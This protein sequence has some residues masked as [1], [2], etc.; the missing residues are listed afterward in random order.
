MSMDVAKHRDELGKAIDVWCRSNV[1]D[2]DGMLEKVSTCLES[3]LD[4]TCTD[5]EVRELN[6]ELSA[7]ID[8]GLAEQ[9]ERERSW[10]ERTKND[11]LDDAFAALRAR[12]FAALQAAG[13][14]GKFAS[15]R[16]MEEAAAIEGCRGWVVYPE[17]DEVGWS[18]CSTEA[19]KGLTLI[20]GT[21]AATESVDGVAREVLS[22]LAHYDLRAK[23]G[24]SDEL[25]LDAFEW[26]KRRLTTAPP[27]RAQP[28]PTPPRPRAP[29]P[30]AT[31]GG[32]GWIAPS[33]PTQFPSVC[34]CKRA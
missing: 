9:A 15:M 31:C 1:Y 24:G 2:R 11:D 28:G 10:T 30:C 7:M 23:L 5:D 12:G 32:K 25:V 17:G 8:A 20:V 18:H 33:D 22:V 3:T 27:G 14:D 13:W 6:D 21:D 26:K 4:A 19:A 16:A 34:S 29:A